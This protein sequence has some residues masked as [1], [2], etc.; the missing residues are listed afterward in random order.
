MT[1]IQ[2]SKPFAFHIVTKDKK[3]KAR[4]GRITTPHGIVDIPA[5]VPVGTQATVKSLIPQDLKEI[6]VQIFFGNTYHLHLR[7]GED[8]IRDFGGLGKFMSWG[9]P[10]MTDSGG[11][12][13]FSLNRGR[14]LSRTQISADQHLDQQRGI[15]VIYFVTSFRWHC[16]WRSGGWGE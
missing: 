14:T 5:F 10:T 16:H 15:S 12:Q 7:P 9:G 8:I 4:V 2:N 1:K 3:T 11:F 13:A 6:G